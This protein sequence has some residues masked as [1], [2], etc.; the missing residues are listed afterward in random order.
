M[1]Q[2]TYRYLRRTLALSLAAWSLSATGLRGADPAPAVAVCRPGEVETADHDFTGRLGPDDPVEVRAP[3]SGVVKKVLVRQGD[4]VRKGDALMECQWGGELTKDSPVEVAVREATEDLKR[5]TDA[6]EEGG[7]L[8]KSSAAD[9]AKEYETS[10]D[11]LKEPLDRALKQANEL[12]RTGLS[13]TRREAAQKLYVA[14]D[15]AA[16]L[17]NARRDRSLDTFFE[18]ELSNLRPAVVLAIAE[19]TAWGKGEKAE[20][21]TADLREIRNAIDRALLVSR[22]RS[23]EGLAALAAEKDVAAAVLKNARET[24]DAE[25]RRIPPERV[26]APV[27]GQVIRLGP[28]AGKRFEAESLEETLLCVLAPTDKVRVS[29]EMDESTYEELRQLARAGKLPTK[30][31]LGL[32]IRLALPGE[33]G[34]P[35]AGTLAYLGTHLDS[36]SHRLHCRA[37]FPNADGALTSA[38]FA[39][40]GKGEPVRVRLTLGESKKVLLVP[41]HSVLTDADGNSRVLVVDDKNRLE[42]RPVRPGAEYGNLQAVAGGLR[43][44]DWVVIASAAARIGAPADL[45]PGDFVSDLRLLNLK[46]GSTVEPLHVPLPEADGTQ[47]AKP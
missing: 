8:A 31:G 5:R 42:F 43:A 18:G 24:L 41:R 23:E 38:A 16:R 2:P 27:A 26:G 11:R 21:F 19:V 15:R 39:R 20:K 34:F 25:R 17:A 45:S 46:P 3:V 22:S 4:V 7:K 6:V 32:P 44:T 36:K 47:R 9:L 12:I 35:H 14:L 13:P 30:D 40:E 1:R 29:F 10:L 28:A 37:A 33:D